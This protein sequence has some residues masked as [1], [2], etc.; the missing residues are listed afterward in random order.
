[1]K[2]NLCIPSLLVIQL[3]SFTRDVGASNFNNL[4]LDNNR[5]R[6]LNLQGESTLNLESLLWN[7]TPNKA[8]FFG[9]NDTFEISNGIFVFSFKNS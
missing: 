4:N 9:K 6:N 2:L 5:K 3:T 1:M 7:L 8:N